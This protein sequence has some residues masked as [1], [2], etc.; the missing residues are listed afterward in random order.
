MGEYRLRLRVFTMLLF[1]LLHYLSLTD[2][3]LAYIFFFRTDL[4]NYF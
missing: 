2:K 3:H 4:V 1:Y